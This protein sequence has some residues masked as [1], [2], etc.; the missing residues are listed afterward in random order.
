MKKYS[1]K[2]VIDLTLEIFGGDVKSAM[3]WLYKP[4]PALDNKAPIELIDTKKGI[5][6]VMIL[7][8]KTEH[9]LLYS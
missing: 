9:G 7:L 3:R 6:K 2:D 5:Q 1:V 8:S 4:T